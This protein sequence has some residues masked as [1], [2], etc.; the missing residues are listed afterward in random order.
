MS[1][2]AFFDTCGP[3][4]A[5]TLLEFEKVL[6][7][8]LPEEFREF[9]LQF[10]GAAPVPNV[11]QLDEYDEELDCLYILGLNENTDIRQFMTVHKDSLSPSCIPIACDSF[12]NLICLS[13]AE[14]DFGAVYFFD[15]R[16]AAQENRAGKTASLPMIAASFDQFLDTLRDPLDTEAQNFGVAKV[17]EETDR[18]EESEAAR[19]LQERDVEAMEAL[20]D[21]GYNIEEIDENYL[22]LLENAATIGD[23]E[24]VRLLT[25]RGAKLEA[26]LSIAQDALKFNY[27]D[28]DHRGIVEH[29]KR[30]RSEE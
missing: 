26:A 24:M 6:G 3:L 25:S 2:P 21:S 17:E 9:L 23:L 28:A 20:L 10:N 29:L 5:E 1:A 19:I 13:I 30:Y 12:G 15:L 7:V 8:T 4:P 18:E 16:Q 14:R 27:P 22:T 11:F